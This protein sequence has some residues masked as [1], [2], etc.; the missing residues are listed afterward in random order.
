MDPKEKSQQHPLAE[1]ETDNS[2]PRICGP[3][4]W[5]DKTDITAYDIQR[6]LEEG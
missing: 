6:V 5:V 4:W 1:L 2:A 3:L